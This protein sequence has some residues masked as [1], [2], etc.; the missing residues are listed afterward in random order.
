[1]YRPEHDSLEQQLLDVCAAVA[2]LGLGLDHGAGRQGARVAR[3]LQA[4]LHQDQTPPLHGEDV[5][6]AAVSGVRVHHQVLGGCYMLEP[7]TMGSGEYSL[8][9]W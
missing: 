3:Q 1:M 2:G 5:V 8:G 6:L 9:R 4:L 7:S